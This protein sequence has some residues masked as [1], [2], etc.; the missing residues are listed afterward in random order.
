VWVSK[1][2][3]LALSELVPVMAQYANAV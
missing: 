3:V 1:E 2:W